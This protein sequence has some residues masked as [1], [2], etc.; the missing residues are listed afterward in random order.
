MLR[1][2]SRQSIRFLLLGAFASTDAEA[3]S[4]IAMIQSLCPSLLKALTPSSLPDNNEDQ[5]SLVVQED[6]KHRKPRALVAIKRVAV[7]ASCDSWLQVLS[8]SKLNATVSAPFHGRNFCGRI[9]A[10]RSIR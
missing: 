5:E 1:E 2:R 7:Q 9:Y 8:I 3:S 6:A 10:G 4:M